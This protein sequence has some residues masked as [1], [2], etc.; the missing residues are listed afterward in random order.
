[1]QK[2]ELI[3]QRQEFVETRKVFQGQSDLISA[4]QNDAVF[5]RLL[6]K[7]RQFINSLSEGEVERYE[8]SGHLFKRNKYSMYSTITISGYE[9][10]L[11]F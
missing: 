6:E 10:C 8:S 2:A 1:M 5:F 7:H 9:A 3:L 11:R 4:Q